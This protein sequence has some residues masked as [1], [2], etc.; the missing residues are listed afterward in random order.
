MEK[1]KIIIEKS[2]KPQK[3]FRATV[4]NKHVYFGQA[5]YSDFTLH[6]NPERKNAYI[7]RHKGMH[8]N[9]SKTGIDTPGFWARYLLWEKPNLKEAAKNIE[10]KFNVK[11]A[12]RN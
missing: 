6:K 2:D 3:K 8:E 7:N 9:W 10:K 1:Q 12:L 5:G 4:G 11:V